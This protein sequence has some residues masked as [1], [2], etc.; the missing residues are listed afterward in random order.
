MET[1]L[2]R[3]GEIFIPGRND[4]AR[5]IR[6]LRTPEK[7]QPRMSPE[8]RWI[9]LTAEPVIDSSRTSFGWEAK[10]DAAKTI[11]PAVEDRVHDSH[12]RPAAKLMGM[13]PVKKLVGREA[14]RREPARYLASIVLCPSILLNHETLRWNLL[15]P[16]RLRVHD[17]RHAPPHPA[18]SLDIDLPDE[19]RSGALP[20][21]SPAL[22]QKG[23]PSRLRGPPVAVSFAKGKGSARPR[24]G[25]FPGAFWEGEFPYY[26]GETTSFV[27]LR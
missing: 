25:K 7:G 24:G 4:A 8:A 15:K 9:P 18:A 27:A 26:R 12:G 14:D 10:L 16:L 17:L 22:G 2:L 6:A 11:S 5:L 19:G 13:V 1:L 20:C 3:S 23:E 21:P